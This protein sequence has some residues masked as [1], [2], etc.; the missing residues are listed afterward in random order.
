METSQNI[1][2]DFMKAYENYSDAIFRHC[3]FRLYDR[4]RATEMMQ[5]TFVRTWEQVRTGR[6]IKN[7]RAFLYRVANNLVID[8]VRKRKESSLEALMETGF[9]P[10][11]EEQEKTY[12]VIDA[13]FV[14]EALKDLDA[15][16]RDVIIMRYIDDLG[17]N[18][19]AEITGESANVVSVRLNRAVKSAQNILSHQNAETISQTI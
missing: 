5:E 1:T 9:E 6:E 8:H 19:I 7:V 12:A 4:E 14:L 16:S 18:E 17:P 11:V 3:Y 2:D 10:G 15:K 13:Q